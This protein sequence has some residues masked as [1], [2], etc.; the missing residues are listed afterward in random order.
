VS[1]PGDLTTITVT[2]TYIDGSG[3]QLAGYVTFTPTADLVDSTG[4]TVLRAT[5]LTATLSGGSI[6]IVL[7]CTDNATLS[8]DTWAYTIAET[9]SDGLNNLPI[10]TYTVQLPHTLGASVDLSTLVPVNP[11]TSY[12]TYY[13]VLA[14]ANTWTAANAFSGGISLNGVAITAPPNI[15]TEFLAADGAWRVP[16]G[17]PPAGNAGG[18]LAGSYPNP[19]V[20][21]TANFKTQ[22][23]TV[24]LD[25]MTA[26][27]A[28][29]AMNGQK[30]TGGSPGT[31]PTDFA[32]VG[33]LPPTPHDAYT[34]KLGLVGQPFPV[35]AAND[36]G[37]GLTAGFLILA[38]IRP[39]A[40]TVNN[41]GLLLGGAGSGVTGVSSMGLFDEAGN[42]LAVTGDMTSALSN[43]ANDGTYVEAAVGTPYM[44]ADA[45]SY[46]VG[47]LCQMSSNPTIYGIFSGSGLHIPPIRNHRAVIVVGGQSSMPP[48][49][50]VAGATT[51]AAAYWLVAS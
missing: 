7:P 26:P 6:S 34:A 21:A 45:T 30:L 48:S 40:A 14:L 8:P 22:V 27:A 42:Q 35:E 23:A 3:N 5:P 38:L 19:T 18:D 43:A 25:Q 50:S 15:S 36:S 33:Q 49:F 31:A 12:S 41:L 44:T 10:R 47:V 16:T 46:Y 39:G 13:G 32:T 4:H 1:L 28:A 9:I 2:G 37:L 24:R 17:G 11:P 20:T 29:V 51:A